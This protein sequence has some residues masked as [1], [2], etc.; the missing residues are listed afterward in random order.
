MSLTAGARAPGRTAACPAARRIQEDADV[1]EVITLM[2]RNYERIVARHG[3]PAG[4]RAAYEHDGS[5]P[6]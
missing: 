4:A 5:K 1:A 6:A 3:L 2:R